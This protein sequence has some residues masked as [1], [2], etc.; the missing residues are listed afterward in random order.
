M[1]QIEDEM[2]ARAA[3][4]EIQQASDNL[5]V[6]VKIA[7]RSKS[8]VTKRKLQEAQNDAQDSQAALIAEGQRADN[9]F[10]TRTVPTLSVPS[11]FGRRKRLLIRV[12]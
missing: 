9:A 11:L 1:N 7:V 2:S 8:I 10:S 6:A 4:A 5:D 12:R 3:L